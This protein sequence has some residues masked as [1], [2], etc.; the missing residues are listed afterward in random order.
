MTQKLIDPHALYEVKRI[1][2]IAHK[3]QQEINQA[4]MGPAKSAATTATEEI[5]VLQ[6]NLDLFR[7]GFEEAELELES[8][9]RWAKAWK[10]AATASYRARK[11]PQKEAARL[12][13]IETVYQR[14]ASYIDYLTNQHNGIILKLITSLRWAK[15]WKAAATANYQAKKQWAKAWKA[16]KEMKKE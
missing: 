16:A 9:R 12:K 5:A 13:R 4:G 14:Q 15:A 2:D 6:K 10:A 7:D 3:I 1:A 8:T 11:Q